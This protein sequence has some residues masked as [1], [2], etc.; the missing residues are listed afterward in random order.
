M[1]SL[2]PQR[3]QK[4]CLLPIRRSMC[5]ILLENATLAQWNKGKRGRKRYIIVVGLNKCPKKEMYKFKLPVKIELPKALSRYEEA[6][7]N[8]YIKEYLNRNRKRNFVI[9]WMCITLL[10]PTYLYSAQ[11]SFVCTTYSF[12]KFF[13]SFFLFYQYIY[14]YYYTY[15]LLY[16]L[17]VCSFSYLPKGE[18]NHLSWLHLFVYN[19]RQREPRRDP[20]FRQVHSL[21]QKILNSLRST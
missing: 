2:L 6:W 16:S 4:R 17:L 19:S 3:L 18:K 11:V 8:R 20:L 7:L 5:S 15:S 13:A 10:F 14:N 1:V 9:A 12:Y 21:M